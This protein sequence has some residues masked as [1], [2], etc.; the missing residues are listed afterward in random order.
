MIRESTYYFPNIFHSSAETRFSHRLDPQRTFGSG[1]AM[2]KKQDT[3]T[4]AAFRK[5]RNFGR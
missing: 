2:A 3:A 1:N 5:D 4:R